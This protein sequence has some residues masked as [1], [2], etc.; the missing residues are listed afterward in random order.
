MPSWFPILSYVYTEENGISW[1]LGVG[2]SADY[3]FHFHVA[4]GAK[5][6]AQRA[7]LR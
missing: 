6:K 3:G 5:P 4:N 1:G 7:R 2:W